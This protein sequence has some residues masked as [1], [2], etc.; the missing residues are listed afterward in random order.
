MA[1]G[2]NFG[3]LLPVSSLPSGEGIGTLGTEAYNFVD[4]L[5]ESGGKIW[6]VL[7]LNPTNYGDSPYQSCSSDALNYY[8]IDLQQLVCDGLLKK[9]ETVL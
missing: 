8:F 6:Q 3:I 4:F 7:P 2:R 9:G 1:K 5:S